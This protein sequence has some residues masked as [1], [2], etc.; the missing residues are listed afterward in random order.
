MC[1]GRVFGLGLILGSS[2][3]SRTG[4]V[5]L[6]APSSPTPLRVS[7]GFS[8][9]FPASVARRHSTSSGQLWPLAAAGDR[10]VGCGDLTRDVGEPRLPARRA[11]QPRTAGRS[12][13]TVR[14]HNFI[15]LIAERGS[16]CESD[17]GPPLSAR[18]VRRTPAMAATESA[19]LGRRGSNAREPGDPTAILTSF[20]PRGTGLKTCRDL[21]SR[22]A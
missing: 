13:G 10:A 19:C 1:A 16:R 12:S 5:D 22:S 17:A 11:P 8:P 14:V 3:P 15:H 18:I 4:S 9:E 7:P 2:F 21:P 6:H 20:R